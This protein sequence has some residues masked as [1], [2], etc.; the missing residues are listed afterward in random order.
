MNIVV[1]MKIN[2]FG[3][4]LKKCQDLQDALPLIVA[5]AHGHPEKVHCV[6][7]WQ[8]ADSNVYGSTV[9]ASVELLMLGMPFKEQEVSEIREKAEKLLTAGSSIRIGASREDFFWDTNE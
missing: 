7:V 8:V 2:T 3:P 5:T 9:R 4:D 6:S 1:L